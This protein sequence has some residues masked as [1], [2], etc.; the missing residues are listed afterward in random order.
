MFYSDISRPMCHTHIPVYIRHS[1]HAFSPDLLCIKFHHTNINT[2]TNINTL[3][4]KKKK[5]EFGYN[6]P[7]R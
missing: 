2:N 3:G 1:S 4:E 5:K 7:N 6:I